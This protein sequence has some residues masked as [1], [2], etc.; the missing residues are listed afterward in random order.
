M[1][2]FH[3]ARLKIKRANQHIAEVE[4]RAELVT[5]P[6]GQTSRVEHHV[7]AKVKSIHYL[8]KRLGDLPEIACVIGDAVHNFKTALDYAW[9]QTIT[10]LMPQADLRPKFPI[11][12]SVDHLKAALIKDGIK[13]ASPA[14]F[15]FLVTEIKP[16]DGGN[17]YLRPLHQMDIR[18]KHEL[19]L[20][21]T[22]YGNVA[23]LKVQ[24]QN[25]P[26]TGNS[27]GQELPEDFRIDFREDVEILDNGRITL[28]IVFQEGPLQ[29]MEVSDV[30]QEFSR[31]VLGVVELLEKFVET[32]V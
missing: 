23:G 5:G 28:G 14:L 18:D 10:I 13:A 19:L 11:Y 4:K 7:E 3:D 2:T 25:G 20:P 30:L 16:Y 15:A 6:D 1:H 17:F 31:T 22:N 21:A 12:P 9:F 8:L 26:V 27:W 32:A 24:D 29:L